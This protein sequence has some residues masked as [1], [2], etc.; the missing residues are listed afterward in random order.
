LLLLAAG[1]SRRL[2]TPKQLLPFKNTTLIHYLANVAVTS[3][4][5]DVIVVV[6][7]SAN[8]VREQLKEFHLSIAENKHWSEGLSTSIKCGLDKVPLSAD[9][10]LLMLCDQP[11]VTASLLDSL[12]TTFAITG[13]PVVACEYGETVG[14]PALFS[15][16]LVSELTRLT[17]DHGAKG[18]IHAHSA[19]TARVP[20]PGGVI[21]IDVPDDMRQLRS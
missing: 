10:V 20:F 2:G 11:E 21:D 14:V 17:G 7:S 4:A 19:E 6:G 1:A 13:S 18:V 5:H 12:I 15:M 3:K 9:G 16:D 8:E